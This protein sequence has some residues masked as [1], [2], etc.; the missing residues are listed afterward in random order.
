LEVYDENISP[1]QLT[2]TSEP[3]L[4]EACANMPLV[5]TSLNSSTFTHE[6][7]GAIVSSAMILA[8]P[9]VPPLGIRYTV[10]T[11]YSVA[12]VLKKLSV[13]TTDWLEALAG[14]TTLTG[15][16][17]SCFSIEKLDGTLAIL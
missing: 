15:L 9:A 13:V 17:D 5:N 1:E 11:L 6:S 3:A 8:V 16:V 7:L 2:L 14:L 4:T 12:L 10:T